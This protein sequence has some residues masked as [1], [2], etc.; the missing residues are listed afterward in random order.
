VIVRHRFIRLLVPLLALIVALGAT[1]AC[2]GDDDAAAGTSG[3]SGGGDSTLTLVG[4]TTPREV[5]EEVIPLFQATPAGDGIDFEQSYGPSGDQSRAVEA[6]LD[7]DV[8]VL[9]LAPDVTRLEEPGIVEPG[10]Q[11]SPTKGFVSNSVVV[12]AVREGNPKG[13]TDWDDLVKD[14][15]EVITPNPFTSGGAQWNVAAAYGAQL[16]AGKSKDEALEYLRGLFANVPVQPKGARE[17]L[18][19]FQAG[20]GDVLIAYENEARLAQ[21][22]GEPIEYVIPESTILIEN[23][24]AITKDS[25]NPTAAQAFA[26][27]AV[28]EPAQEVFA[29]K[30]YRSVLPA[31]ADKYEA[32]FPEVPGLFTMDADLGGWTTFRE[33][34]FDPD[35]GYVADVFADRGFSQEDE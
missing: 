20:K 29:E 7:A 9:S 10:W 35:D 28:S 1:V 2:G 4:Y 19:V 17:S 12:L 6:G 30:G 3:G 15:V 11:D 8:L 21:A 25:G 31:V 14:D 27:F 16:E 34:F 26:D 13:I 24:I 5:Y 23:P 33:E 18:Q 32:E 22:N